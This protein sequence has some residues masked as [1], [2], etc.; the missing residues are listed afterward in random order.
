[1]STDR[2]SPGHLARR[3]LAVYTDTD[4]IDAALGI[5]MLEAAGFEVVRLET[6]DT[7]EIVEAARDA[8]ALLVGYANL[9]RD[10]IERMPRLKI[11]ALLSMGVDN[12]DVDAATEHGV[13]VTNILGAAT[14]E[15]AA[16]A[17]A[18]ALQAARGID[19][20]A[21]ATRAG[22][23]RLEGEPPMLLS[24]ATLGVVGL[25]RIGRKL[26]QYA[27]PLFREILGTDP[28]LPDDD[29]TRAELAGLGV[30]RVSLEELRALSDV[31][32]LHLPLTPDTEGLVDAAFLESMPKG[33]IL[34]NVSRGGLVDETAL[35]DALDRGRL[36]GA[37]LDVTAVEPAPLDHPFR[38]HPRVV[39]TPHVA[40]LSD[41]T[42]RE[43]VSRQAANVI[44]LAE[45]GRPDTPVNDPAVAVA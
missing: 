34:V 35:V 1:M 43:Y 10:M 5:D 23:W 27:Q 14:E 11:A 20:A 38:R 13:W 29:A 19:R 31:V 42:D 8:E 28:M 39:L 4:G 9:T 21:T 32:S 3:P 15:V 40:Y 24:A 45:R 6:R 17:L 36:S 37:A 16:H 25:G 18:L 30:R 22:E 2:P 7:D 41:R 44:A 33:S 12:V 26:A